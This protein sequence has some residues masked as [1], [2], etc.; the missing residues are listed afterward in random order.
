[1]NSDDIMLTTT[2]LLRNRSLR[3]VFIDVYMCEF[4]MVGDVL[5]YRDPGGMEMPAVLL[6]L[7]HL[8]SEPNRVERIS[9]SQSMAMTA[10]YASFLESLNNEEFTFIAHGGIRLNFEK[11]LYYTRKPFLKRIIG[12]H[13]DG[14]QLEYKKASKITDFFTELLTENR[15]KFVNLIDLRS[16]CFRNIAL[17][18]TVLSSIDQCW[19]RVL[20][21]FSE[22]FIKE[23][24]DGSKPLIESPIDE[25]DKDA[26]IRGEVGSMQRRR[27][28]FE[29]VHI[30]NIAAD[31]PLRQ[32]VVN[33]LKHLLLGCQKYLIELRLERLSICFQTWKI[34]GD[35]GQIQRLLLV[36][37]YTEGD[38]ICNLSIICH[39]LH[40][41]FGRKNGLSVTLSSV[42]P[43]VAKLSNTKACHKCIDGSGNNECGHAPSICK[44]P[45]TLWSPLERLVVASTLITECG[46]ISLA[47]L[48]E[49]SENLKELQLTNILVWLSFLN[50]T[51][52]LC[53]EH[54]TIGRLWERLIQQIRNRYKTL[55]RLFLRRLNFDIRCWKGLSEYMDLR[56][57]DWKMGCLPEPLESTEIRIQEMQVPL[58]FISHL[59][60]IINGCKSIRHVQVVNC[61]I[62]D[63]VYT[64][65]VEDFTPDNP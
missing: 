27:L 28:M 5:I 47:G 14:Q 43:H 45:K 11:F 48:I 12:V 3:E 54:A 44:L 18:C 25:N 17:R 40:E 26:M 16:H 63:T 31:R 51:P 34:L 35:L 53:D 37:V 60:S 38:P 39:T 23:V 20:A 36:D 21:H 30:D 33:E 61:N 56:E 24:M 58:D 41:R 57:R 10:I 4:V 19:D 46:V 22:D 7:K 59:K 50:E 8:I 1:M 42:Y 32:S 64:P 6:P 9:H 55:S 52:K 62:E 13:F 15:V 29:Q 49:A 65:D 2:K